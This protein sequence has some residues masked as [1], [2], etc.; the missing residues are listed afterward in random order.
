MVASAS[1]AP[2]KNWPIAQTEVGDGG[3]G[4]GG[5]D[6]GGD[7]IKMTM[8]I[9]S[10]L[11]SVPLNLH[12][13]VQVLILDYN[14]VQFKIKAMMTLIMVNSQCILCKSQMI[15]VLT[16]III[17]LTICMIIVILTIP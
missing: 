13:E 7:K 1:G 14:Q 10:G 15:V 5:D 9:P 11:T 16:I 8:M 4:G 6:G 3:V 2:A 12:P 17:S